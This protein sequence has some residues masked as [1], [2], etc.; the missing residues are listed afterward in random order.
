MDAGRALVVGGTGATGRH[1]LVQLLER[2]GHVRAIVRS[3]ERV[4]AAIR[5]HERLELI[6]A[7]L[8]E[9]S[10]DELAAHTRDCDAILCCLGHTLSFRGVFGPPWRLVTQ[11]V[12]RLCAA[13]RANAPETPVR[14]VLMGSS[15]V[16]N[17]DL[18]EPISVGQHVV[19]ALLRVLVPPHADNEQAAKFLRTRIPAGDPAIDWCVVRPD[20]LVDEDAVRAYELHPS[21]TRSAIFDAGKV[22]RISVAHVMAELISDDEL[23]ANWRGRMPVVYG[24]EAPDD[25]G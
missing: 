21:P 3:R 24:E 19:L 4:P 25:E 12:R 22:S 15:G 20:S 8:L 14:F 5:D 9:L 23:W 18:H 10:D 7:S 2:G 13:A 1:L 6:E 11:A 16:R 17:R